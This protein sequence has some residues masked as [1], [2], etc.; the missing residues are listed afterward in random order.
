MLLGLTLFLVSFVQAQMNLGFYAPDAAEVPAAVKANHSK[1]FKITVP[2]YISLKGSEYQALLDGPNIPQ[3]TKQEIKNCIAE[4]APTC[5]VPFTHT[6]GTA[7]L[8]KTPDTLWTNCHIVRE[9]MTYASRKT[10]FTKSSQVREFFANEALPMELKDTQGNSVWTSTDTAVIKAVSVA[11]SL[12]EPS[13]TCNMQDDMVKI[14]LSR[15]LAETGLVWAKEKD[16]VTQVFMGGFPRKTTSR[17]PLGKT[18]SDGKQFYWTFGNKIEKTSPEGE[19]YFAQKPNLDLSLTGPFSQTSLADGV[20]GMSGSPVMNAK[21]EVLG[22]YNG[23]VPVSQD[24]K[25]IPF[26]SL[27]IGIGGMRFVEILS[28]E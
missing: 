26:V 5:I 20:E 24:Q 18:D 16:P 23:F 11:L 15:P 4:K 25:E 13:A 14:Q 9:W 8:G 12:L 6:E 27:F 7:F 10:S 17:G 1:I 21:G 19:A 2:Y 22:I 28:G 3:N